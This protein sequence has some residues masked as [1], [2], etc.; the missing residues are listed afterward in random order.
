MAGC[1]DGRHRSIADAHRHQFVADGHRLAAEAHIGATGEQLLPDN[2]ERADIQPERDRRKFGFESGKHPGQRRR[3][4]R[5]VD[6][7]DQ[8]GL[9]PLLQPLRA[10]ADIAQHADHAARIGSIALPSVVSVGSR[11][12][13]RSNSFRPSLRL[14]IGDGVADHRL[15]PVELAPGGREAAGVGNG[16]QHLQLIECGI[17]LHGL[18][19]F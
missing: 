9:Q 8:L 5:H 16:D 14:Q 2:A 11:V 19:K 15:R 10:G 13:S 1:G 17:G 12:P 3:R 4:R 7:D 18:S 6:R